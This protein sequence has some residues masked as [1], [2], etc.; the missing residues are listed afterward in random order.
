MHDVLTA[1]DKITHYTIN[2]DI[3]AWFDD[4]KTQQAV[5][6]NFEII[7]EALNLLSR[8]NPELGEEPG[9]PVAGPCQPGTGKHR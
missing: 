8:Q 1:C 3:G 4:D 9:L 5:E 7:G 6:R 2:M